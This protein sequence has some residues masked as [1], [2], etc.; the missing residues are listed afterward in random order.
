[1][2]KTPFKI[3]SLR[4]LSWSAIS[5]FEYDKEQWYRKYVLNIQDPPTREMEFGKRF[6]KAIEDG[7]P[8]A[9][10]TVLPRV[11]EKL[12]VMFGDIPLIGFMDT[13]DHDKRIVGEFKTGKKAW[14]QER[15]DSHGQITMYL[16]MLYITYKIKPEDYTCFLE[17]VQTEERG[18]FSIGLVQ[19]TVVQHFDTKRTMKD[20]T[21]F[22][23][24]ILKTVAEMESFANSYS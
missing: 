8:M 9:P 6:A 5:S 19:P 13:Y 24:R 3:S 14:T 23:T 7:T 15:V 2:K 12:S 21:L 20:I 4:P 22:G 1:M 18:D 16:L 17:S 10:V 11:E